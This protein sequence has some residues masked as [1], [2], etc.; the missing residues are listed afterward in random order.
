MTT[1]FPPKVA[2]IAGDVS[3]LML[4]SNNVALCP[5]SLGAEH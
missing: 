1:C 5:L 2:T 3:N 4:S